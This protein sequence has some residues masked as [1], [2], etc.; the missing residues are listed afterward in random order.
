MLKEVRLSLRLLGG[1]S[2]GLQ[3]RRA[4]DGEL[5]Q[6]LQEGGKGGG[7][8]SAAGG[9]GARRRCRGLLQVLAARPPQRCWRPGN[10]TR[11]LQ[12]PESPRLGRVVGG[13]G[14]ASSAAARCAVLA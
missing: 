1:G 4:G 11:A 8:R 14:P 13:G 10:A 2:Q 3:A 7:K 12:T 5:G 9:A 6:L